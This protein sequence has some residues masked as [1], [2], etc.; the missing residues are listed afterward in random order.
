MNLKLILKTLFLALAISCLN[1]RTS[2]AKPKPV[3]DDKPKL[4]AEEILNKHLEAIGGKEK[5]A[6]IKTR[7]AIGTAKK[8]DELPAKMAIMSETPNR[9]AGMY[10]F[11]RLNWHLFYD[12]AGATVRP[13]VA[14]RDLA[15][16]FDKYREIIASGLMYNDI[17]LY[18]LLMAGN[19]AQLNAEAKGTKKVNGHLA[20]IV[21][22]KPNKK[23]SYRLFF[24]VDTFM[25]VRT[26]FGKVRT[27]KP[28]GQFTNEVVDRGQD[29]SEVDFYFE[30]SDFREVGGVKLPFKFVQVITAP[31]A[32]RAQATTLVGTITEY[33]HNVPIA[34]EMFK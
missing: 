24:D 31:L 20:Y 1:L 21:D 5:L 11:E 34:A 23:G 9:V 8:D 33:R 16:F 18:S 13:I 14:A 30:A 25:W 26:E 29:D 27:T 2:D 12:G 10:I 22:I 28:I 4:T 15:P 17:S 6:Q 32:R 7:I 19:A 3:M